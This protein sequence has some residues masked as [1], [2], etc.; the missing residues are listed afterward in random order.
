MVSLYNNRTI[1]KALRARL[2]TPIPG[3]GRQQ[4]V[5][6][7]ICKEKDLSSISRAQIRCGQGGGG[8]HL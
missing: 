7:L 1:T 4:S 2:T 5:K 8:A 6:S 3:L